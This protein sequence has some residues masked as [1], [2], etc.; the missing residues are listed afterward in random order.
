LKHNVTRR[1]VKSAPSGAPRTRWTDK[2]VAAC[3]KAGRT[4]SFAEELVDQLPSETKKQP[5]RG[6]QHPVQDRQ[7]G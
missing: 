4:K 6:P 5:R 2:F 3:V 1:S 7:G